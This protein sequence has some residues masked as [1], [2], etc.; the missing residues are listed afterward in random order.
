[1]SSKLNLSFACWD[2]D[3]TRPLID[4]RVSVEGTKTEYVVLRPRE[5]FTR[6][7]EHE[8][9]DVAEVSLSSLARLK[10]NCDDRFVGIPVVLSRDSETISSLSLSVVARFFGSRKDDVLNV[11]DR[12]IAMRESNVICRNVDRIG[13]TKE[14]GGN[15]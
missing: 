3:R 2:Y 8:E 9:F 7:L 15:L 1:M 6:M 13:E 4:G 14:C 12:Y 11:S 10:A 5:A